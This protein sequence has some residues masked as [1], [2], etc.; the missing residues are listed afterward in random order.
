MRMYIVCIPNLRRW[1]S[2]ADVSGFFLSHFRSPT[3]SPVTILWQISDWCGCNCG[4][5]SDVLSVGRRLQ[6][7]FSWWPFVFV[8]FCAGE[9]IQN[10]VQPFIISHLPETDNYF[11]PKTVSACLAKLGTI[12]KRNCK[13]SQLN[14]IRS[15]FNKEVIWQF[16]NHLAGS[17][18]LQVIIYLRKCS[19]CIWYWL[20]DGWMDGRLVW[21]SQ[22][23]FS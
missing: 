22:W 15:R 11:G 1:F 9:S 13:K 19:L 4:F 14:R 6:E 21:K 18:F 5:K 17:S 12:K 23:A 10:E 20:M 7:A 3:L 8:V 2:S 16:P